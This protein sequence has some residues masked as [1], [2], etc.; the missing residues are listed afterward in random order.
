[1][2]FQQYTENDKSCQK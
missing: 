2:I 1:M